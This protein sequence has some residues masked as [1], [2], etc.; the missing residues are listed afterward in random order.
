MGFRVKQLIASAKHGN[1]ET[2]LKSV[3]LRL[4][5]LALL[6][7][8]VLLPILLGLTMQRWSSNFDGL[9]ISKVAS[10][11]RIAEQYMQRIVTTQGN[12]ITALAG[13]TDF[14][15]AA[16]SGK[17]PLGQFLEKM[18]TELGLDYLV[19]RDLKHVQLLPPEQ[20]VAQLAMQNGTATSIEIFAPS[21]LEQISKALVGRAEVPLIQTEAALPS[22][23]QI[24][25][26]GMVVLGATRAIV[27][28]S[29]AVLIG[30]KLLNH[31]LGFIDTINSLV[32]PGDGPVGR[33]KGT[34]T[35][36]LEDVRI[37][38]NV[39]LFE[40]VRA[41]GTRVS[42]VVYDRVL[43]QGQT[44]LNRA[45]VVND[46]YI[47]GYLPIVDSRKNN[48]GMLYVGFLEKPFEM[49]KTS[50]NVALSGAII[51]I[52]L[53]SVPFFLFI[54]SGIFSPLEKMNHTM[55]RVKKGD[56]DARNLDIRSKDEIGEVANHFNELLDQVQ[57]RDQKLRDWADTLNDKVDR[58][59]DELREANDKL[60]TTYK[61]L[62]VSEKLAS[63]GEITAG[64]AHEINNPVAVIQGNLDVIRMALGDQ[65]DVHAT[66]LDLLDTQ[67]HRI[68]SIVSKLLQFA[69]PGDFADTSQHLDV[70]EV[71][72]DSIVLVQHSAT[73]SN[74]KI[75]REF[76]AAP[77]VFM[78]QGELQQVLIN[79]LINAIQA[80]PQGGLLRLQIR[81][82][83]HEGKPGTQIRIQDSGAG[84]SF[85]RID[86]IFDP[87]FT[88]KRGEGT[89]LGLSISQS[90]IQR[91]GGFIAVQSKLG[92]GA[93]FNIWIPKVN[94]LS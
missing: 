70:K 11:L 46:W 16:R 92:H 45:F 10:D 41:L 18:Q 80:M 34:A 4:L 27:F 39:R 59:T 30:G 55:Q 74:I 51:F 88:T 13:S 47:S 82:S 75:E 73:H 43:V 56:L 25:G 52:V 17:E 15:E 5:V 22:D 7:L 21:D 69:K 1:F 72:E 57:E 78:D 50:I 37:S 79:L 35:L 81:A 76:S 94:V 89:G 54:A 9:L 6:P 23:R 44:W 3:R 61:Q 14:H 48:I 87:F 49:Q 93:Q 8:I 19:V 40:N 36:F 85:D 58:R 64:V 68:N 42:E 83:E 63:I 31:N 62:V 53:I 86:H 65:Q 38:T 77:G 66:E 91:A 32:Y 26:R 29:E 28:G 24:E 33:E 71:L 67:V 2:L 20:S 60:E 90:L 12:H 84:I